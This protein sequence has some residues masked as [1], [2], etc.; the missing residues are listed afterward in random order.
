MSF[1]IARDF[2]DPMSDNISGEYQPK[3][4]TRATQ[5]VKESSE[6]EENQTYA[7]KLFQEL[8]RNMT[9]TQKHDTL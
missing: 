7:S 3:E 4:G 2:S 6:E 1:N 9:P 8:P 5:M